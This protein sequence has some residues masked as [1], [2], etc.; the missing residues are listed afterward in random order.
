MN[1]D[2]FLDEILLRDKAAFARWMALAEEPLR[3]S[4]RSFATVVDVEAVLQE[5]MLRVW[6]VAPR[7]EPDGKPNGLLRLAVRIA[8]NLA[9]SEL[10][11]TK[12][13]PVAPEDLEDE[14]DVDAPRPPDPLLRRAILEC[15]Q[16]LPDKPRKALAAR[17]ASSGGD[18]DLGLAQSLGMTLNTFLQNFTRARRFLAE[19]LKR[20]GVDTDAELS[21]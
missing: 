19:C 6:T 18:D 2:V 5:S 21:A 10:R 13:R 17:L 8:R 15:E 11:R 4:L 1:T 3:V 9:V 14:A 20:Q 7:F 16:K 12:A